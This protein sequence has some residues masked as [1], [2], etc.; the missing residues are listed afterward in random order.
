MHKMSHQRAEFSEHHM[1][2]IYFT[3]VGDVS[4]KNEHQMIHTC[5]WKQKKKIFLLP[6]KCVTRWKCFFA[7]IRR[8]PHPGTGVID[9]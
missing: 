6:G 4:Y 5:H 3:F 1:K 8:Y 7:V 9:L 2:T